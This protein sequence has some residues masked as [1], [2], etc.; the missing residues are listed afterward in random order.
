MTDLAKLVV[1]LEAQTAQYMAQLD[2]ANKRLEKFDKQASASA[3]GIAKGVATAVA[4]AT[5]AFAAMA[6]Q[7]VDNA[8]KLSKLSQVTGLSTESLSQLQYVADQSATSIDEIAKSMA[9]LQ[10]TQLS[11]ARGLATATRAFDAIGVSA[12]NADGSLRDTEEVMLDVADRFEK[13]EDGAAKAAIAQELFGKSGTNLIPFLNQGRAG[14]E[15]LKK[16]ADDF[17][18]TITSKAGRAAEQFNDNLTRV[19]A[20]IRGLANQASAQLIPTFAAMSDRFIASARSGG[21]LDA[22][23]KAL[24]TTLK[25][26]VSTGVAVTSVFEQL[27]RVIYGVGASIVSLAKGD[28]KIAADEIKSAFA[29][30]RSNVTDDM[31]TIAKIWSDTVPQIEESAAKMGDALKETLIFDDETAKDKAQKAADAALEQ[32][33][34][35][36][37]GLRQQVETYGMGEGAVIRYRLAQGDLADEVAR[38]GKAAGPYVEQIIRMTDELERLRKETEESEAL[39]REWVAA[40]EEGRRITEQMRT[41]AEVYA[42]TIERLNEL[43]AEGHIIQET[44][45]RAVEAAQETF[46][47]ATREQNKFLEEANRNVQNIL[48]QGLEDALDGGIKKGAKGALQAFSDMLKKMMMQALAADIGKWLFGGE[49]MGSG[50]GRSGG[51]FGAALGA[52]FGGSRD[53]GGRGRRGRAYMIGTGAQ[54][55]LFVPDTSGT[56]IPAGE[57]MGRSQKVTQNIYVQGRVDQRSARQLEL[58]AMRRQNAAAS[59]LG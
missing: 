28:F 40:V 23:V 54:P 52:L 15:A 58:E 27:G 56:F 36:E 53:E 49:G 14:I 42:D 34:K 20:A 33:K 59:R 1:R 5:T 12:T 44:Y 18:L 57:W 6:K 35:L 19:N 43:L 51:W 48:A 4:A 41:P 13:I 10:R 3:S 31:E 9:R 26:L 25:F 8:D 55:E 39:Q 11:A 45:N 30:A 24:S 17:G 46:D 7:A 50:G 38:A 21:A 47:K 37:Q 29:E 32:I 22:A 16:E 2:K